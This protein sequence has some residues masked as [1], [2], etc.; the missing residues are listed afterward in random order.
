[1]SL[2]LA[3]ALFGSTQVITARH[4]E[5]PVTIAFA[6]QVSALRSDTTVITVGPPVHQR[7]G[8]LVTDMTVGRAAGPAEYLFTHILELTVGRD[9]T[10]YVIDGAASGDKTNTIK[11]YD[12][13]GRFVGRLGAPGQGPGEYE[14]AMGLHALRDGRVVVG[15]LAT[16]RI[17]AYARDGTLSESWRF[18]DG[19]TPGVVPASDRFVLVD[20]SPHLRDG[21]GVRWATS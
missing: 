3:T 9:G 5:T 13:A 2:S 10:I 4:S 7:P 16:R 19:W 6:A 11:R 8:V 18:H 21:R 15:N 20:T 17:I 14:F 12:A 1:M